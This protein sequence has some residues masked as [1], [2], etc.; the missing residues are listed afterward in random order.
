M[1]VIKEKDTLAIRQSVSCVTQTDTN[2][3]SVAPTLL[4][5]TLKALSASTVIVDRIG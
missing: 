2:E 3:E 5:D 1:L 4:L